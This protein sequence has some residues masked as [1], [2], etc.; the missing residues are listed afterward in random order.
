MKYM[1]NV[2]FIVC[3]FALA[4]MSYAE[5][6]AVSIALYADQG[7]TQ[8]ATLSPATEF[9]VIDT[10]GSF[11]LV[12]L[13]GYIPLKTE[14]ASA[15]PTSTVTRQ[16]SV[17]STPPRQENSNYSGRCQAITKKG[18][19]CKRNAQAGRTRCWQH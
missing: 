19:Q 2:L 11:I 3:A 14:A 16:S 13:V 15:S 8:I 4:S 17:T 10:V 9:T 7:S 6:R 5:N 12:K 1:H 18:T